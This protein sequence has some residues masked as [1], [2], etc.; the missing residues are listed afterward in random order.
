VRARRRAA[1][2]LTLIEMV[3]A[4][5]ILAIA[6]GLVSGAFGTALNAWRGGFARGREELVARVV[7]ERIAGQLRSVVPALTRKGSEVVVAFDAKE[8]AVRFVTL[9]SASGTAPAQVSYGLA[10]DQ[11]RRVL[12]YREYPWPD[13]DFFKESRPRR[14]ELV[15]EVAGLKVSVTRR[16]DEEEEEES[17]AATSQPWSADGGIL[18]GTV[19]VEISVPREGEETETLSLTVPLDIVSVQ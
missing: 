2:G 8:D 11:G 16:P 19:T 15:P 6:G 7:L 4:L 13:K 9:L 3:L 10:E 17:S 14:E 18:P 1:A 12:V 5:T